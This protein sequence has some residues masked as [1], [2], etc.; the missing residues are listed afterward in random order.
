[1]TGAFALAAH[2]ERFR[3]ARTPS[4]L[5]VRFA[6]ADD[7]L[8][9]LEYRALGDLLAE[10][11]P[12]VLPHYR[13]RQ[14]TKHVAAQAVQ[15][16]IR[17]ELAPHVLKFTDP[18]VPDDRKTLL[19]A[20]T[21]LKPRLMLPN[22]VLLQTLPARLFDFVICYDPGHDHFVAGTVDYADT[23]PAMVRRLN[24]DLRPERYR[25]HVAIGTS[26]GGLPAIRY[27]LLGGVDEVVA[28]SAATP[29]HINRLKVGRPTEAFD[30]LCAC[31]A[32]RAPS[33]LAVYS[34]LNR[35]DSKVAHWLGEH[36]GARLRPIPEAAEHNPL[37]AMWRDGTLADLLAELL[38]FTPDPAPAAP[39]PARPRANPG[40]KG[41]AKVVGGPAPSPFVRFWRRLARRIGLA[42]KPARKPPRSDST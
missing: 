3:A 25:R 14:V 17:R 39:E 38:H 12:E 4:E 23:F 2:V 24:A 10:T 31:M 33:T 19:V 9:P 35:T 36:F 42:A 20:F 26:M 22:L 8:T 11:L 1:M 7:V 21:G 6:E 15:P 27:G 28:I 32:G 37:S 18:S 16:Y 5:T 29:W 30:P 41:K 34:A 13:N 40:Q